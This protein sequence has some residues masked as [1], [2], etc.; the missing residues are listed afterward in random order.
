MLKIIHLVITILSTGYNNNLKKLTIG[1]SISMI[2]DHEVWKH[3]V[4]GGS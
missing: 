4:L 3:S 1:D 2:A